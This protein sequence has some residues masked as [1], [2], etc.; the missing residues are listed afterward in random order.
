MRLN[1][2]HSRATG[3]GGSSGDSILGNTAAA[4]AAWS[5]SILAA[6]VALVGVVLYAWQCRGSQRWGMGSL[7][8][9]PSRFQQAFIYAQGGMCWLVCLCVATH[10][11]ALLFCSKRAPS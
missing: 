8:A 6:G 5:G 3:L 11:F 4:Q 2:G 1:G 10:F 9:F 7:P